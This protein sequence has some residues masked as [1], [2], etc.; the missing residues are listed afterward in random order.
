M[1]CK[2][3]NICLSKTEKAVLAEFGGFHGFFMPVAAKKI[4][5]RFLLAWFIRLVMIQH[6]EVINLQT[7][8]AYL[9]QIEEMSNTKDFTKNVNKREIFKKLFSS[10]KVNP[11]A[12]SYATFRVFGWYLLQKLNFIRI[13]VIWSPKWFPR[14][15]AHQGQFFCDQW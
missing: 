3:A 8:V 5:V 15:G 13:H 12:I 11:K 10:W 6:S 4:R 9:A 7:F 2:K 14:H 1:A